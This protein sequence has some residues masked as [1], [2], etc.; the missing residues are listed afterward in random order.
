MSEPVDAEFVLP[1]RKIGGSDAGPACGLEVYGRNRI[2][3]WQEL[4]GR[5]PR[6]QVD[7]RP[8]RRGNSLEDWIGA[9]YALERGCEVR[10][11]RMPFEPAKY[12]FM[13]GNV[14]RMVTKQN[15][16]LECK[17]VHP[18]A[19]YR[20]EQWG[21]P[22]SDEVPLH[23]LLQCVHYNIVTDAERTDLAAMFGD[24]LRIYTIPRNATLEAKVIEREYEIW[25][26]AEADEPPAPVTV[27]E[28]LALH[29]G[30]DNTAIVTDAATL[31][32]A[33]RLAHVKRDREALETEEEELS[34]RI[35]IFMAECGFLIRE[36]GDEVATWKKAKDSSKTNWLEAFGEIVI[37][38]TESGRIDPET[39]AGWVKHS[40]DRTTATVPGSRRFLLKLKPE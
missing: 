10:R 7:S 12:P 4:T 39:A 6:P 29:P 1:V 40:I 30:D 8:I 23:Y 20:G 14:D 31:A 19:L 15:V 38:M 37:C 3:L 2:T 26:A 17:S 33:E 5:L 18:M 9:E 25:K 22:G 11:R 24:E 32:A 35:K 34:G 36:F 28:V 13:R 27:G 16:V 21:E